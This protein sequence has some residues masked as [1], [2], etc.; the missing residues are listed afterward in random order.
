MLQNQQNNKPR[1]NDQEWMELIQKCRTSGLSDRNWCGKYSIPISTFYTK[2]SKLR[3]KACDI[4]KPP[5]RASYEP[6][7]VV[8][9]EILDGTPMTRHDPGDSCAEAHAPAVVLAIR[10]YR[11]EIA[12]HA[13]EEAIKNTLAALRQLC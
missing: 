11:I 6:Q 10:E 7:Q 8:A 1:R 12:N 9:L 5:R 2:I 4:P 3:K 13:A